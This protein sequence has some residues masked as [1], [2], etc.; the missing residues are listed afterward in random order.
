VLQIG[1]EFLGTQ[2]SGHKTSYESVAQRAIFFARRH[3]SQVIHR[4][5]VGFRVVF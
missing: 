1:D 4:S 5:P 3:H 2:Q